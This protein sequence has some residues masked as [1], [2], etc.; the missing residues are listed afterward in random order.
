MN[1]KQ[2]DSALN[3]SCEERYDYFLNKVASWEE[4]W[5]LVNDGEEFLKLFSEEDKLEYVPIWPHPDLASEYANNAGETL[6][7]KKITLTVFFDR[8]IPGLERD[9]LMLSVFPSTDS[10]VWIMEPSELLADLE[11][12]FSQ[13]G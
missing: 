8:W 10:T 11:E 5:I 9:N 13:G 3:L 12:E 1:Q 7:A 4:V 6:F 2:L